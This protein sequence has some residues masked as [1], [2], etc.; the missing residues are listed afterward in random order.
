MKWRSWLYFQAGFIETIGGFVL[1]LLAVTDNLR[2]SCEVVIGGKCV[3]FQLV[4]SKN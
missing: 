2:N 1:F 4:F 3:I